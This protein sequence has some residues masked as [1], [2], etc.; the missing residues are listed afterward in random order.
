MSNKDKNAQSIKLYEAYVQMQDED[1]KI[2]HEG[3]KIFRTYTYHVTRKI[4]ADRYHNEDS[5]LIEKVVD[6]AMLK[7]IQ[8][9]DA[10]YGPDTF[11]GFI[12]SKVLQ[13]SRKAFNQYAHDEKITSISNNALLSLIE[14][15]ATIFG[16]P[17]SETLNAEF[18]EMID[19]A[20]GRISPKDAYAFYL[21]Y[22]ESKNIQETANILGISSGNVRTR[23]SR[24]RK[25]LSEDATLKQYV[26]GHS[27][28]N[29][30]DAGE[31]NFDHSR[32]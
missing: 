6:E 32:L 3:Y 9:I 30:E 27:F 10:L 17:L 26:K 5:S 19:D 29:E 16:L 25:A 15:N 22:R 20:L 14:K 13:V 18:Y 1:P 8:K 28:K 7:V 12:Q 2:A 23:C 4:V 31:T 24:A 11:A 21:R